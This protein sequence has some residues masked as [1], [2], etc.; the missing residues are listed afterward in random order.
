MTWQ[1]AVATV[2]VLAGLGAGAFLVAQRP[3]FWV[4]FGFGILRAIAP[5]IWG[6]LTKRLPPAEEAAWRQAE[7]RGQGDEWRKLRTRK[8]K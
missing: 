5:S 3:T 1:E 7:R 6:Y 8:R 4:E 2:V